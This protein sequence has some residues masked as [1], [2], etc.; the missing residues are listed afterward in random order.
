MHLL[1][2]KARF[3][4][5]HTAW[6]EPHEKVQSLTTTLNTRTS[7]VVLAEVPV[8]SQSP[9][10]PPTTPDTQGTRREKPR[11]WPTSANSPSA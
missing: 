8:V 5:T 4:G 2:Y 6:R 9:I 11:R 3:L 1:I 10:R 7:P